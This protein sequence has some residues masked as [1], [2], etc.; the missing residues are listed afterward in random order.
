[1]T[2]QP[3]TQGRGKGKTPE[4]HL[5]EAKAMTL[6]GIKVLDETPRKVGTFWQVL[7]ECERCGNRKWVNKGDLSRTKSCGCLYAERSKKKIVKPKKLAF[8]LDAPIV[9][10]QHEPKTEPFEVVGIVEKSVDNEKKITLTD[11][12]K[13]KIDEVIGSPKVLVSRR[14]IMGLADECKKAWCEED[15]WEMSP[16]V[17]DALIQDTKEIY[18]ALQ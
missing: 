12:Q 7:I 18:E 8:G 13:A 3:K 11:E 6:F 14:L 2:E 16:A 5:A 9:D 15:F 10:L 4:Q 1:M 17:F